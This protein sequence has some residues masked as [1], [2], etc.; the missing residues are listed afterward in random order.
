MPIPAGRP[1]WLPV[2]TWLATAA[3]ALVSFSAVGQGSGAGSAEPSRAL[4]TIG[5]ERI[6]EADVIGQNREAFAQQREDY[7]RRLRNLEFTSVQARHTLLQ[8]QLDKMLDR[9]ALEAEA[10]ARDVAP[11]K[12]LGEIA[13]PA[14]TDDEVRAFY[15][16][17]KART[18][19]TYEQL[20]DQIKQYLATQ[21]NDTATRQFYDGLRAKHGIN[22]LL[23]PLRVA[24]APT[25]PVRGKTN[26][27]VTIV[28]FADFQCP[29]CK[30]E[31]SALQAVLAKYP[32]EVRLVFR[33]LPLVQ[34]HPDA[35]V[36]AEA[37][38][39]ADHQGKFWEMHDALYADQK[40][41]G[42]DAITAAAQHLG[43]NLDQLSGCIQ[44]EATLR[45][46]KAD[47]SAA[48][49]I[50]ITS[51]PYF[52][53]NGR[54]ISGSVPT[55]TLQNMVAEELRRPGGTAVTAAARGR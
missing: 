47:M 6:S 3:T 46:I 20:A 28:E 15:E 40:S 25:G 52:F 37:A 50:G 39:C 2:L 43:L 5:S 1:A 44:D 26:V 24:V 18:S 8:Q 31:E 53:I 48:D 35:M 27:P 36:A 42:R 11:D 49:A 34:V 4:A 45:T 29:Y 7:E 10:K 41:L 54:P 16:S 19:Q 12:V 22:S 30:Q 32:N 33:H 21:H 38:V 13:V 55:E 51:T 9:R 17:N 23:E 14:V